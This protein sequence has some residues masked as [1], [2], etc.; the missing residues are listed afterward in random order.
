M[1]RTD[2]LIFYQG[3]NIHWKSKIQ[4]EIALSTAESEHVAV[5]Q[6][7]RLLIVVTNE[8]IDLNKVLPEIDIPKPKIHIMVHEDNTS[9]I[10]MYE[11]EDFTQRTKHITL[12]YH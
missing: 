5:N 8:L 4:T 9:C 7:L 6:L 12:T 10:V 1:S 11:P 3:C 2:F